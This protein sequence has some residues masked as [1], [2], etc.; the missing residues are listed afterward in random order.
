MNI[1]L[2]STK[3]LK[4][5][6]TTAGWTTTHGEA[7]IFTRGMDALY[8]CYNTRIPNMTMLYEFTDSRMNFTFPVTDSRGD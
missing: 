2:Q 5:I 8:Y 6:D 4:Y 1:L 3:T 7:R